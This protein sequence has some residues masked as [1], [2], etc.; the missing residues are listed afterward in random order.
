MDLKPFYLIVGREFVK[1]FEESISKVDQIKLKN[2]TNFLLYGTNSL[3][4]SL[5]LL[6]IS[7]DFYCQF[8]F[9][10]KLVLYLELN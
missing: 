4:Y 9:V 3:P 8:M 10:K 1:S 5:D 7:S 6:L 2:S